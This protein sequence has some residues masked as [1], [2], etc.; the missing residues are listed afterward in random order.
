[1]ETGK[2][3]K[4][5]L[6]LL[7][8]AGIFLI[9]GNNIL[10]FTDPDE[11]FYV[12]TAKEMAENHTWTVPFLFGHPQFEKP[13]LTYWLLRVGALAFGFSGF[14]MRFFPA[15]FGIVGVFTVYYLALKAFNDRRKAFLSAL[16]LVSGGLYIGLARTVFT[17]MIFSILILLSLAAFYAGY[18]DRRR[19]FIMTVLSLSFAG[20]AVLTKGPLGLIIPLM[21]VAVFLTIRREWRVVRVFAVMV[22]LLCFGLIALPWYLEMYHRFGQQFINEFFYNCHWRRLMEAEHASNDTWYFYLSGILGGMMP[23]TILFLGGMW[24]SFRNV[25]KRDASPF[26]LFL[27]VWVVVVFVLFQ[28]AHSKLISY[29]FPLFPAAAIMTADFIDREVLS[30]KKAGKVLL[31]LTLILLCAVPVALIVLSHRYP[32]YMPGRLWLIAVG[33]GYVVYLGFMGLL[34]TAKRYRIFVYGLGVLVPALLFAFFFIVHDVENLMSSRLAT[35]ILVRE[36]ASGPV[37]CSKSLSRGIHYYSGLDVA[38]AGSGSTYFSPH[39]IPLLNTDDKLLNFLR[40]RSLTYGVLS[41]GPYHDLL[42]IAQNSRFKID[43]LYE[44]KELHIVRISR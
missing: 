18:L 35:Q 7:V 25:M 26:Y 6:I 40:Q 43:I 27:A 31:G 22:G 16:V 23:W 19:A 8:V 41:S 36:N 39:P 11:V 37:I 12:G 33:C 38:V 32:E 42:R 29:V 4:Y 9:V 10:P 20:L 3:V 2:H 13:I 24:E 30:G 14:A 28:S 5:L 1:M 21:V 34:L 15:L 44:T 17:D